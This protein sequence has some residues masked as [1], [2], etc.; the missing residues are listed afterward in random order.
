M[1]CSFLLYNKVSQPYVYIYPLPE[2]PFLSALHNTFYSDKCF[3]KRGSPIAQL[4]K[5]L[6]AMQATPVRFLVGKICWRRD[7][8]PTQYCW[9]SLW[10]S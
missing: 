3:T 8:L 1:L 5:N 6:A 4:V 9:A 7:R 10:L 2:E